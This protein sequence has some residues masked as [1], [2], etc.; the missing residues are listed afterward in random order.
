[1][2]YRTMDPQHV[3]QHYA[4]MTDAALLEIHAEDLVPAAH[5]LWVEELERR[6][7]RRA[8]ESLAARQD[9]QLSP[10]VDH[11]HLERV[12][13][14]PRLHEL[15]VVRDLLAGSGIP[16]VQTRLASRTAAPV[17]SFAEGAAVLVPSE[18]AAAARQIISD[19][20]SSHSSASE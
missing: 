17:G 2:S 10:D 1:M 8:A 13:E 15:I 14:F 19:F 6:G 9:A 20:R 4:S 16:V 5:T 7:L 11:E 3:K 12:G 18:H